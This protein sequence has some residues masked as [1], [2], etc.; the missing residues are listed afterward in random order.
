M[1]PR[2]PTPR[3]PQGDA[4]SSGPVSRPL[5]LE[6][7][8]PDNSR[9]RL[10]AGGIAAPQSQALTAGLPRRTRLILRALAVAGLAGLAFHVA[11]A[12]FGFGGHGADK[13]A[14]DWVYDGVNLGGAPSCLMRAAS[15][16]QD[17]LAWLL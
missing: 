6:D 16:R 11:H 3:A 7:G 14:N 12:L 17:R 1:G 10:F 15:V 2:H 5:E 9:M 4:I 8:R 13:L